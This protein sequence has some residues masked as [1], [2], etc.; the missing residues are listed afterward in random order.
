MT[1]AARDPVDH[2]EQLLALTERLTALMS[3][4][5]EALKARTL[6]ASSQ[7]WSEKEQLAH[8]Y[9]LEMLALA[10][11]PELMQ[12]M[13]VDMRKRLME[14][15]RRFQELLAEHGAA[16]AAMQNIS[17]GLVKS[18]AQEIAADKAGPRGYS[19]TGRQA[20]LSGSGIAVNAKA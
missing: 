4:E 16:L 19:E 17:E 12:A 14:R 7:D 10:K 20:A 6:D 18:I 5:T 13:P 11:S 1:I 9:R 2:C 15:T 3:R 8:T